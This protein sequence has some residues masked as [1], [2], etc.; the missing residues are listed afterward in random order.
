[1]KTVQEGGDPPGVGDSYW[2]IRA[3]E[4]IV[5][6]GQDWRDALRDRIRPREP[7]FA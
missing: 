2:G 4:D 5:P 1:V 6:P 7:I 3:I